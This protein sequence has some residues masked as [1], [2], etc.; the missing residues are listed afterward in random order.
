M[1]VEG[2]KEEQM[3]FTGSKGVF[4]SSLEARAATLRDIM[5]I[6]S[7]IVVR[8]VGVLGSICNDTV[9]NMFL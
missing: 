2:S 8:V 5:K 1:S 4:C 6:A 9:S 3:H 7:A